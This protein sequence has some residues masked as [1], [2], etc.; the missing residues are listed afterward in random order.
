MNKFLKTLF[1]QLKQC[2]DNKADRI[3]WK[4]NLWLMIRDFG[5]SLGFTEDEINGDF[6]KSL[7]KI[8]NSFIYDVKNFASSV[9]LDKIVQALR[10]V[11]I[12]NILQVLFNVN[13]E[14]THSV[15]AY[16]MLYPYTDNYLDSNEI[17][18]EDKKAINRRFKLRLEGK[19]I[20]PESSYEE[21]IFKLVSLI[22]QQYARESHPDLFYS[23]LCI[24]SAQ[25]NS[26][27]Q[28]KGMC[29]PYDRDIL[30]ISTE[31]GGTSVL[32]D[33]YL[34]KGKLS[35]AQADFIFAYGALLQFCDDLQDTK[36]DL[37]NGHMTVFSQTAEKWPLD[38]ITNALFSFSNAII[39]LDEAFISSE[40]HK[41]K[42][43]LK[44][45]LIS[46]IFEAISQN[47]NLYSK[48]YIKNIEKYYPFRMCYT[49]KLYKKIKDNY[50]NFK[51]I[52]GYS[53]DEV[54]LIATDVEF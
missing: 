12:M 11:W 6:S 20:V 32:A 33:A 49:K 35:E 30:G 29:S 46:L 48:E 1:S 10:N 42:A 16:S 9:T 7:P 18:L 54:I 23:L 47:S 41:M 38:T 17:S 5:H 50:S 27:T 15:F 4:D 8:T 13:V 39:D 37:K 40:A 19:E 21:A 51:S 22:E 36:E 31:K 44:K 53:I 25:C 34:I 45:N 28:Q 3:V 43:F 2:P 24:H 52:H 26:L 14:Y